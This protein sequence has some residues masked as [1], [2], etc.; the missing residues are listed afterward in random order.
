[1]A[2]IFQDVPPGIG[3]FDTFLGALGG[4][5][6][7]FGEIRVEKS[8]YKSSFILED[9]TLKFLGNILFGVSS[10]FQPRFSPGGTLRGNPT[11]LGKIGNFGDIKEKKTSSMHIFSS[12]GDN[13][14]RET[15]EVFW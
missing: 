6:A 3:Y 15:S 1:M 8:N 2:V 7:K 9:I 13:L 14:T 10:Q 11:F 4:L 5:G 12:L